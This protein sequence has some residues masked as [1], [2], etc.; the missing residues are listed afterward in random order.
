M[1]VADPTQP[2]AEMY[3]TSELVYPAMV[4]AHHQDCGTPLEFTGESLLSDP[5]W[6]QHRCPKCD[7]IVR[8]RSVYPRV[9][10]LP[11]NKP[12]NVSFGAKTNDDAPPNS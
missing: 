12:V 11:A 10:F 5:P 1:S 7:V 3:F 8:L 4:T 2:M 6:Y 9:E